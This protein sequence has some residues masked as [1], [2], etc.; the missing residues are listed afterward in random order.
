MGPLVGTR[1]VI[2]WT[3]RCAREDP[4]AYAECWACS[5]DR[6]DSER[7]RA[8]YRMV[9]ANFDVDG[10]DFVAPLMKHIDLDEGYEH[11]NVMP[12]SSIRMRG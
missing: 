10:S 4:L 8:F 1:A 3:R 12:T 11:G 7:A 9:A 5:S 2:N 6:I